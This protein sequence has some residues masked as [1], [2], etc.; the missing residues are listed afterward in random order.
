MDGHA[1]ADLKDSDVLS[2]GAG[3]RAAITLAVSIR[4]DMILIDERKGA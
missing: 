2:L 4:A 3:E 1:I